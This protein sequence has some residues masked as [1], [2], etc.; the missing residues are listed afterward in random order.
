[1]TATDSTLPTPSWLKGLLVAGMAFAV[2]GCQLVFGDFEFRAVPE[3]ALGPPC[4][5]N[6]AY[7]C[8]EGQPRICKDGSWR[9]VGSPCDA[10]ELCNARGGCDV[11][12]GGTYRC[13]EDKTAVEVC[14]SS[15]DGW[16]LSTTCSAPQ[17][18]DSAKLACVA[19]RLRETNCVDSTTAQVC[20][21]DQTGFDTRRCDG[22]L[23]CIVVGEGQD[24]CAD[25]N[26]QTMSPVCS[27]DPTTQQFFLYTCGA[28]Y[29]WKPALCE[30]GCTLLS[31]GTSVCK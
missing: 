13:S 3:D 20:R 26:P 19:C 15:S 31:T 10:P 6:G 17:F 12:L 24:Y 1:M 14:S 11:C 27:N 9:N 25:C 21:G 29:R 7:S 2:P 18:C 28:D 16:E 5:I 23:P 30:N 4:P 8:D 22:G